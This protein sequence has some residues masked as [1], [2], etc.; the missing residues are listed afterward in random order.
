MITTNVVNL[1]LLDQRPDVRLLQVLRLVLVSSSKVGAHAAVVA[2]DDDTALAGGLDMIDT[3]LGVHTGLVAS[4][5]EEISIVVLADAAKVDNRVV[6]EQVLCATA[7]VSI[8][9]SYAASRHYSNG[10]YLSATSGVLGST[11]SNQLSIELHQLI[12]EAHVLILC[13]D[14]VVVLESILLQ[15]SGVTKAG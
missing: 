14:G 10:S 2:S 8:C 7:P 12:V 11:T 13:E 5:P 4:I 15:E 3:V 9:C 6:G 1:G